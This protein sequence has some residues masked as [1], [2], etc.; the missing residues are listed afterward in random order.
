MKS[1]EASFVPQQVL[2]Q[3]LADKALLPI[4][5]SAH[6]SIHAVYDLLIRLALHRSVTKEDHSLYVPCCDLAALHFHGQ[7]RQD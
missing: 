3:W 7:Y 2:S 5:S 6:G 4:E 1:T